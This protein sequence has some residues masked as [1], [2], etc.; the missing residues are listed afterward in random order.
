V[1]LEQKGAEYP[2]EKAHLD[3]LWILCISGTWKGQDAGL[4]VGRDIRNEK[5]EFLVLALRKALS[6]L[7]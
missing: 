2:D 5:D 4:R 3:E 6:L 1:G 7:F